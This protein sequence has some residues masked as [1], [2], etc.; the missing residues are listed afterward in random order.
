MVNC[1]KLALCRSRSFLVPPPILLP[2]FDSASSPLLGM[3]FSTIMGGAMHNHGSGFRGGLAFHDSRPSLMKHLKINL[4]RLYPC[5][6]CNVMTLSRSLG[7][8]QGRAQV[9]AQGYSLEYPLFLTKNFIYVVFLKVY[10]E[11]E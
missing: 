9:G 11:K 6:W 7:P 1:F 8:N 5:A 4:P 2:S 10:E 3:V